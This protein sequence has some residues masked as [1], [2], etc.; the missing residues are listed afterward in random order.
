MGKLSFVLWL[1]AGASVVASAQ[2]LDGCTQ[3]TV[4]EIHRESIPADILA[5]RLKSAGY[6]TSDRATAIAAL[7]DPRGDVRSLAA[8]QLS[9]IGLRPDL[10]PMIRAWASEN[11]DCTRGWLEISLAALTSKL[12]G[13]PRKAFQWRVAPFQACIPSSQ[14]PISLSIGQVR[15]SGY[16]GPAIRVVVRNESSN[17]LPFLWAPSATVLFSVTV[18]TPTGVPA[19]VTNGLEWMYEPIHDLEHIFGRGPGFAPLMPQQEFSWTWRVGEDFEMS[20]PGSYRVSFGGRLNYLDAT[21]CSNVAEVTV[22]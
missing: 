2:R 17:A 12:R 1:W 20:T 7:S 5:Q 19:K 11:D 15:E 9:E 18:L 3:P 10:A 8:L 21:V 22:E 6:L 14:E 4:G 16:P 13:D